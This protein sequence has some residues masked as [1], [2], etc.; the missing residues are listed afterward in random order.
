[1]SKNYPWRKFDDDRNREIKE[2][3][4]QKAEAERQHRELIATGQRQRREITSEIV[5]PFLKAMKAAGNPGKGIL[6]DAW[7]DGAVKKRQRS[8]YMP[9]FP[10][11]YFEVS[12]DAR[13][14]FGETGGPT[15]FNYHTD[16]SF[17]HPPWYFS[18]ASRA[19]EVIAVTESRIKGF[20]GILVSVLRK[21]KIPLP[22]D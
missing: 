3:Q 13:W 15:T 11:F 5:G 18:S 10:R 16:E 6:S 19:D 7:T 4:E 17:D 22:P 9:R 1:V 20:Q 21:Y 2:V 14:L 12:E 8:I